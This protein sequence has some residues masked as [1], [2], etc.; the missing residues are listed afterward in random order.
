V[1]KASIIS[2]DFYLITILIHKHS[3]TAVEEKI[4]NFEEQNQTFP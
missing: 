2:K 4:R 1:L 3:T